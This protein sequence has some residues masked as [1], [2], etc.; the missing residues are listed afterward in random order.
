MG[1]DEAMAL[2]ATMRRFT[3]E[4]ADSDRDV[5]ETLDLRVAQHPSESDRYL[6]ARLLARVLEHAEGVT[7][8]RGLDADDEPAL[9]QRDLR[10]DLQA[11]IEVGTPSTDRLHKAAKSCARVVVYGWKAPEQLARDLV[12]AGVH[13]AEQIV[14]RGLDPALLDEIAATLERNNRWALS[15]TGGT[16]YLEIGERRFESAVRVVAR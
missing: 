3:I 16:L 1:S 4:V 9:W 5:Y 7:F 2:T 8:T 14:I 6:V 11:W 15:I 10:G 12:E 13:R